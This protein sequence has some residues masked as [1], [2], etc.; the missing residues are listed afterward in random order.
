MIIKYSTSG[1]GSV[2]KVSEQKILECIKCNAEIKLNGEISIESLASSEEDL[3][4]CSECIK[5]KEGE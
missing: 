4:L 5:L 2:Y 3:T 1:I